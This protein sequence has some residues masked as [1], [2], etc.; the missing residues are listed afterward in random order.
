MKHIES[1]TRCNI[2][3]FSTHF[4]CFATNTC[5][6]HSFELLFLLLLLICIKNTQT[7]TKDP[8]EC[9]QTMTKAMWAENQ[10]DFQWEK[11]KWNVN[12]SEC[13][14]IVI[15]IFARGR[16]SLPSVAIHIISA[17]DSVSTIYS[18]RKFWNL[19]VCLHET[20]TISVFL[21]GIILCINLTSFSGE[22]KLLTFSVFPLI[23]CDVKHSM[24]E[25]K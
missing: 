12:A 19:S 17:L 24:N 13:N 4:L 5:F 6:C 15:N 23:Q 10:P 22:G 2:L 8:I 18:I 11:L 1:I 14:I 3:R 9:M 21:F 20:L 7:F 16:S 25:N